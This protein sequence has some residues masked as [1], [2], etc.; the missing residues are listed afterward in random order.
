MSSLTNQIDVF[1]N[2]VE[3]DVLYVGGEQITAEGVVGEQ[4]P[5]GPQG[6][7]GP[8]GAQGVAGPQ[9][10]QG[11][12]GVNGTNGA[13][14]SVI[15]TFRDVWNSTTAYA[16]GDIII[17]SE[18]NDGIYSCYLC[19]AANT[20]QAPPSPG[21]TSTYWAFLATHGAQGEQGPRGWTGATGPAGA[22]GKDGKDGSD[23]SDGISPVLDIV[24]LA[25]LVATA[26]GI[27][28]LT[29]TVGNL[30]TALGLLAARVTALELEMSTSVQPALSTLNSKTQFQASSATTL[31]TE[32]GG[33]SLVK[34]SGNGLSSAVSLNASTASTFSLGAIVNGGLNA[35]QLAVA[36]AVT[37]PGMSIS[38]TG[39]QTTIGSTA[40][41]T[42]TIGNPLQLS[43]VY[44]NGTIYMPNRDAQLN[45]FGFAQ[46]NGFLSQF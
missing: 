31:T 25:T 4:G 16:R 32:F 44:I 40:A 9:G 23:G 46:T 13:D 41:S 29:V 34:T 5:P 39:L 15:T 27:A 1:A 19:L 38:A 3:T 21:N 18:N 7:Q 45:S 12:P 37:A 17:Y 22:D 24:E 20:N 10:A 35:D 11:A 42:V 2:V 43:T 28:G 14:G 8:Q 30:S 33:T 36:G 26:I 6:P